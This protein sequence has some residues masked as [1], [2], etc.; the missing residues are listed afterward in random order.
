[1]FAA[2]DAKEQAKADKEFAEAKLVHDAAAEARAS[3]MLRLHVGVKLH[4]D[5]MLL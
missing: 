1:M 5:F 2:V 3:A 4:I